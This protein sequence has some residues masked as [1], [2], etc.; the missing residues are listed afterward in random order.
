MKRF[1]PSFRDI[2]LPAGPELHQAVANTAVWLDKDCGSRQK[3]LS[4][5]DR[6]QVAPK[7]AT[8]QSEKKRTKLE[9]SASSTTKAARKK[10]PHEDRVSEACTEMLQEITSKFIEN[11]QG[12]LDQR[13]WETCGTI[14]FRHKSDTPLS[15]AEKKQVHKPDASVPRVLKF[16]AQPPK[17]VGPGDSQGQ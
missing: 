3:F 4:I 12:K 14:P 10:M 2:V 17:D 16:G 6:R 7:V 13:V 1:D 15:T 8:D 5:H 11:L 9:A